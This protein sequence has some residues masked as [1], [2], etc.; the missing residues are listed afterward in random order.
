MLSDEERQEIE[1][2]A[3]RTTR[4][5]QA[6]GIEALKIVQRHRG[7]VS[8][9]ALA[10]VARAAGHDRRRAG[11]RRHLLQPDLPPAGRAARHPGL[12]QRQLL[13]HGLRP[14]ARAPAASG[15]ASGSGETTADGRFTLLPIV[16]LG[17]CD[18][19]P[20][21]M[22]DDDLHGD[23][24]AGEDR[25][26]PGAVRVT[27]RRM[28]QPLTEQHAPRTEAARPR[29]VRAAPAATRRCARRCAAWRPQDVHAGGEGLRACAAAAARAS[30][31]AT[32]WSFVP[33][34]PG[35]AAAEVP[36]RQRRR[37]GAGHLQGPP[38]AGGRPAP[39]DRGHDH[40]RLRHRG[41]RRPT[42]SCAGEYTLA[43]RAAASSAIAEAYAT[44]ATSG[45]NILGSGFSL[46]LHLHTE[47]RA[48]TCAAR[49]PALL[50]A[51][52]GKRANPRAKPPF[53]PGR[54][55]VGQA[56]RRQ[57]RRDALQRAAH[58]AAT[59]RSGSRA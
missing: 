57:Q 58:R 29:G 3:A 39:A 21:M 9:E 52:E 17:A 22:V 10:D 14:A 6:A 28:E 44:R 45:S 23:L 11:R 54:R 59:A 55:A 5:A 18:Q 16:C 8:D 30:R 12:R 36:G 42:S 33:D 13:D 41:R 56:D 20:A 25:R 38:A 48:A 37:D 40:R 47:R 51:L 31:P 49:R 4:Q 50:N 15:W 46:E 35:R 1:A 2:R 43:A 27:S 7:W 32:K 53:P 34:G 26:D 19:A 24:D